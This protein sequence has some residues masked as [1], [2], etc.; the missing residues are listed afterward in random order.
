QVGGARFSRTLKVETVMPNRLKIDLDLGDQQVIA[1]S[2]VKG[3]LSAQWLSG[4]TAANLKAKIEVRLSP[5]ATRF[6]R[7]ADFVFDDPARSFSGSPGEF[8]EQLDADGR[9]QLNWNL[10]VHPQIRS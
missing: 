7:N 6:T 10:G 3:T 9:A 2:P 1:S 5:I 8:E 4:A